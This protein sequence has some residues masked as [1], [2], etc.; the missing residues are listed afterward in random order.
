MIK[1]LSGIIIPYMITKTGKLRFKPNTR[2]ETPGVDIGVAILEHWGWGTHFLTWQGIGYKSWGPSPMRLL[3]YTEVVIYPKKLANR[4]MFKFTKSRTAG[5]YPKL[6]TGSEVCIKCGDDRAFWQAHAYAGG[7]TCLRVY[8]FC[9]NCT[10]KPKSYQSITPNRTG[11]I[12]G[13]QYRCRI[14]H[15]QGSDMILYSDENGVQLF[16]IPIH[17]NCRKKI[18][19][20]ERKTAPQWWDV[21]S[22]VKIEL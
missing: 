5:D 7:T 9:L 1:E 19:K 8:N 16:Q 4:Y 13:G 12:S 10:F 11:K 14:C 22:I 6:C 3:G 2:L 21:P 20:I 18:Y 15:E 17:S